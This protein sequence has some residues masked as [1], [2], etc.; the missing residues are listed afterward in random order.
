MKKKT[1]FLTGLSLAL[2]AILIVF[3]TE[4]FLKPP[5]AVKS[6]VKVFCFMGAMLL[7]CKLTNRKFCDAVNFH[8]IKNARPI[9]V[10]MLFFFA[11]TA[12]AFLL[13]RGFLDLDG[14]RRSL[15]VKEG[16]TKR[17]CIF[18][19]LYIILCNSFL[20]ESFFR[21]FVTGLF[22]DFR[23]KKVG[24]IVSAVLFSLYHIGIFAA[25]FSPFIFLLCIVGLA[26]VGLFLQW[27]SERH[28]SILAST[29]TH[30][31]ANVAIDI[32]GAL[33]IFEVL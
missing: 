23:N 3:L 12:A 29:V 18:V 6:A 1:E 28:G 21:G 24:R 22:K 10:C 4:Q 16:L 13:F 30:A 20:E 31:C 32:I 14:I 9:L 25:W 19:F 17:N 33:L 5:Y 2:L 8:R 11:G 26:L 7:Y 15:M 27:L